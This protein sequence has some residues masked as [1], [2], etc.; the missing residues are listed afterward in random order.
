M[1]KTWA[2]D[3]KAAK[4]HENKMKKNK[5]DPKGNFNYQPL[6]IDPPST[7]IS[8]FYENEPLKQIKS[9]GTLTSSRN[10]DLVQP[11]SFI[12]NKI[13][14]TDENKMN[15]KDLIKYMKPIDNQTIEN[16][17]NENLESI[18]QFNN[19]NK[20]KLKSCI[21]MATTTTPTLTNLNSSFDNTKLNATLTQNTATAISM[22]MVT[23]TTNSNNNN[24]HKNAHSHNNYLNP[25][26]SNNNTN[27]TK[28]SNKGIINK[29]NN[30]IIVDDDEIKT[31]SLQETKPKSDR[32]ELNIKIPLDNEQYTL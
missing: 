20:K 1:N 9:S 5:K 6:P 10:K 23:N 28:M 22:F 15:I 29:V 12:I 24:N 27:S 7:P 17:S 18:L 30:S 14:K 13:S 21:P 11:S 32:I 26:N 31:F 16:K 2:F 25:V 8:Q 4:R 19:K 3:E